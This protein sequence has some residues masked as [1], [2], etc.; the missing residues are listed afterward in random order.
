MIDKNEKLNEFVITDY[1]PFKT[2]GDLLAIKDEMFKARERILEMCP[3]LEQDYATRKAYSKYSINGDYRFGAFSPSK[4]RHLVDN[5][6]RPKITDTIP[7]FSERMECLNYVECVYDT[8]GIPL[9]LIEHQINNFY[10][11]DLVIS[12]LYIVNFDNYVYFFMLPSHDNPITRRSYIARVKYEDGKAVL[13]EESTRSY[14][15]SAVFPL[16]QYYV[17]KYFTYDGVDCCITELLFDPISQYGTT[18][19]DVKEYFDTE[20]SK[21]YLDIP[22]THPYRDI[23][24]ERVNKY[25][26]KE[27]KECVDF[28]NNLSLPVLDANSPIRRV[29]FYELSFSNNGKLKQLEE[30]DLLYAKCRMVYPKQPKK[31]KAPSGLPRTKECLKMFKLRLTR[32][33]YSA[34]NGITFA[35]FW[36]VF[37][38]FAVNDKF[39]CA[40]DD[41][42][43]EPMSNSI[44]IARQFC[45]NNADGEYEY[46]EQLN[47]DFDILFTKQT[48][49]GFD[50]TFWSDG[51]FAKFFER[52]EQSD[53]FKSSN[54]ETIIKLSMYFSKV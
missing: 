10:K 14:C 26:E 35:T 20:Y 33:G 8:E 51:D 2:A 39:D 9:M 18:L 36:K 46:M 16:E 12:T 7:V 19:N 52:V 30:V 54:P 41:L 37:K 1:L 47:I 15:P 24:I 34:K 45:H 29:C 13:F 11:N 25:K 44:H 32:T 4:I 23:M 49:N 21:Q 50:K 42:L 38:E 22:D 40:D 31:P 53:E 3:T 5:L 48:E 6:R 27:L 43:W 28:Y 17:E